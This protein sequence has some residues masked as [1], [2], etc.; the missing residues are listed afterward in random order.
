MIEVKTPGDH[1][2][3]VYRGVER[4]TY[5][6]APHCERRITLGDGQTYFDQTMNQTLTRAGGAMGISQGSRAQ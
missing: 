3:V 1:L 5:S 2:V 6:C 4:E